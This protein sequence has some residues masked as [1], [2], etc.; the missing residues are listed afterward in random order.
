MYYTTVQLLC[1]YN[2]RSVYSLNK[3]LQQHLPY[4]SSSMNACM[5]LNMNNYH[6][7]PPWLW[8]LLGKQETNSSA[9]LPATLRHLV[10]LHT[11]FLSL[12]RLYCHLCS[13]FFRVHPY[14]PI[15]KFLHNTLCCC[16]VCQARV[17][18]FVYKRC[19][20]TSSIQLKPPRIV[21][22]QKISNRLHTF[23]FFQGCRKILCSSVVYIQQTVDN[24]KKIVLLNMVTFVTMIIFGMKMAVASRYHFINL[25]GYFLFPKNAIIV[26][27]YAICGNQ[28][29]NKS[30]VISLLDSSNRAPDWCPMPSF[31]LRYVSFKS[32]QVLYDFDLWA[33]VKF[34]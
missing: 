31:E 17:L 7:K 23:H 11:N 22:Q 4:I 16:L 28:N 32:D 20:V 15:F 1:K 3:R 13:L 6:P 2:C 26:S 34:G 27:V 9:T 18:V 8:G 21:L 29:I 25:E 24:I 19:H 12:K 10:Q 5:S 14:L 33:K 30:P